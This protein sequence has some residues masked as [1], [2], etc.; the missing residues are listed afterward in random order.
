MLTQNLNVNNNNLNN[1]NSNNDISAPGDKMEISDSEQESAH[2]AFMSDE[3]NPLEYEPAREVARIETELLAEVAKD[4]NLTSAELSE[5]SSPSAPIANNNNNNNSNN[6]N[7]NAKEAKKKKR[8]KKLKN[9]YEQESYWAQPRALDHTPVT[10]ADT[11]RWFQAYHSDASED[12][13]VTTQSK[14]KSKIKKNKNL[15]KNKNKNK[16]IPLE[17]DSES[18]PN[19]NNNNNRNDNIV[20]NKFKKYK[21]IAKTKR[22]LNKKNKS[23]S[24]DGTRLM[25]YVISGPGWKDKFIR[26]FAY[27]RRDRR[28]SVD[29]P[30]YTIRPIKYVNSFHTRDVMM[31]QIK[32]TPFLMNKRFT[33]DGAKT[34]TS[35]GKSIDTKT[36]RPTFNMLEY[37]KQ[38][39]IKTWGFAGKNIPGEYKSEVGW[40]AHSFDFQANEKCIN[41][42][43][44]YGKKFVSFLPK[45]ERTLLNVMRCYQRGW[46]MVSQEVIDKFWANTW[47]NI[48]ECIEANGDY[49]ASYLRKKT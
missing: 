21:R 17:T 36:D 43:K 4:G 31:R 12:C 38:S 39:E 35:A 18:E 24:G 1:N 33:F 23:R 13:T 22:H 16:D 29:N 44:V 3:D 49:G 8:I 32:N 5:F 45:N 42:I 2:S 28:S 25:F 47:V 6:S 14:R 46:E 7:T 48:E 41:L 10:T 20:D 26:F 9:D 37:Y 15:N 19:N 40:P 27:L 11:P 30:R 34:H